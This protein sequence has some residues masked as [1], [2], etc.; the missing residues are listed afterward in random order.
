MTTSLFCRLKLSNFSSVGQHRK[1]IHTSC[2]LLG[3][4]DAIESILCDQCGTVQNRRASVQTRRLDTSPYRRNGQPSGGA[5][6]SY[7]LSQY[8][9]LAC[10][11]LDIVV[12][13][14][15]TEGSGG[16][17]KD[18][19]KVEQTVN[20][21]K[22]EIETKKGETKDDSKDPSGFAATLKKKSTPDVAMKVEKSTAS[23]SSV[24]VTVAPP[25]KTIVQKVVAELKH[26]YNGFKLLFIDVN[27]CRKYIWRVLNG[28]SLTRRER[29]QVRNV[30]V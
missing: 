9:P 17:R 3:R 1:H 16:L 30:F 14:L 19:S 6:K 13:M 27:V 25:K 15:H 18:E 7:L 28:Q 4:T 24:E 10:T 11:N 8:T 29:R 2:C 21:L 23:S 20:V 12:R 26:Y 5:Y 22:S